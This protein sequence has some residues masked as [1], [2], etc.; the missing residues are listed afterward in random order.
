MMMRR[1]KF[2]EEF[3][4]N[5]AGLSRAQGRFLTALGGTRHPSSRPALSWMAGWNTWTN[6][7]P[8]RWGQNL[9]VLAYYYSQN[10]MAAPHLYSSDLSSRDPREEG[11]QPPQEMAGAAEE[12]E[13]HHSMRTPNQT[14]TALQNP[15]EFKVRGAGEVVQYMDSSALMQMRTVR[16]WRAEE[17]VQEGEVRHNRLTRQ[18][19]KWTPAL[20]RKGAA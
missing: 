17:D 10:P 13:Q 2:G 7:W 9:C 12:P 15:K 16:M 19:P 5:I 6:V 14:A 8:T 1:G 18:L 3:R 4:F 11:Q 20:G